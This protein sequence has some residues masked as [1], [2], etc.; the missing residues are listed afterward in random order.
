L[1]EAGAILTVTSII[2]GFS[3]A[4]IMFRLQRELQIS[5]RN[6][7]RPKREPVP[8]W[9]PLADFLVI[10]AVLLSFLG[11]V[12]PLLSRQRPASEILRLAA[13]AC[14]A[15]TVLLAGY[16]P[17]ILAH[18]RFVF[19]L[20]KSRPYLQLCEMIFVALTAAGAVTAF[21]TVFRSWLYTA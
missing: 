4:V 8:T 16:V 9:L 19:C 10:S 7:Q 20:H 13:A 2:A 17:S 1:I 6:W 21:I 18:Y 3:V 14:A 11:A 12:L 5:D 15:S